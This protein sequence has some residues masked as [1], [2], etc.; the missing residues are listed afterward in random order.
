MTRT[1][2]ERL[3]SQRKRT[4]D[5]SSSCKQYPTTLDAKTSGGGFR[6]GRFL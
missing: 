6:P 4:G 3:A 5:L 1:H 2:S